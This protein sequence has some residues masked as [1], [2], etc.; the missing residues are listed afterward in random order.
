M[1]ELAGKSNAGCHL[2]A[3]TSDVNDHSSRGRTLGTRLGSFPGKIV[4]YFLEVV[5]GPWGRGWVS[6]IRLAYVLLAGTGIY[7]YHDPLKLS[8]NIMLSTREWS[9]PENYAVYNV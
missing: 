9:E 5:R 3:T 8:Y 4:L 2:A 7:I 6:L 1:W